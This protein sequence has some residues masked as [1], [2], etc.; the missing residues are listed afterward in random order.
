MGSRLSK[1]V[2]P[3]LRFLDVSYDLYEILQFKIIITS[4][5][6]NFMYKPVR[7]RQ[8]TISSNRLQNSQMIS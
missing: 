2:E 8:H 5:K 1:A 7:R 6:I 3:H 4:F